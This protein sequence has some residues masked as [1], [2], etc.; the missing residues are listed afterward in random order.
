MIK[1]KS[2]LYHEAPAMPHVKMY[3]QLEQTKTIS[4]KPVE[5]IAQIPVAEV[6]LS[7]DLIT[8]NDTLLG[9]G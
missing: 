8:V 2:N 4:Q 5:T 1:P 9:E 6:C 7:K 3:L